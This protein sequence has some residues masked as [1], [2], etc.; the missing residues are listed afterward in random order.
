MVASVP[1][2][3]GVPGLPSPSVPDV[4]DLVIP[5]FVPVLAPVLPCAPDMPVALFD[6]F[7]CLALDLA[8][9]D[10]RLLV[11]FSV[12]FC[13]PLSVALALV[14]LPVGSLALPLVAV[15]P[16]WAKAKLDAVARMTAAM[17]D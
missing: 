11:I 1:P 12:L 15:A 13:M 8:W 9:L 3:L 16:F 4:V 10:L 7:E 2:W 5:L 17:M 14:G 6:L